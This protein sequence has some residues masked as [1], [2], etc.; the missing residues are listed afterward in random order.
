[1]HRGMCNIPSAS[2]PTPIPPPPLHTHTDDR[3]SEGDRGMQGWGIQTQ[4]ATTVKHFSQAMFLITIHGP[5]KLLN[6][7]Q[8][9]LLVVRTPP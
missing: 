6:S 2:A 3:I 5:V 9:D 7:S 8:S 1:M 4:T